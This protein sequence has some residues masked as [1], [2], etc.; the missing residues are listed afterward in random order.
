MVKDIKLLQ[1]NLR[2]HGD[3]QILLWLQ[4]NPYLTDVY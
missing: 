3:M 1:T 4:P 2:N